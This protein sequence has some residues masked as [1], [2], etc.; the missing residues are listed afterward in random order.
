MPTADDSQKLLGIRILRCL[1][2]TILV[3]G[4]LDTEALCVQSGAWV[5]KAPL[6]VKILDQGGNLLDAAVLAAMA[7]LSTTASLK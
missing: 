2:R 1:E 5:W 6:A 7:G 4:A 3:G